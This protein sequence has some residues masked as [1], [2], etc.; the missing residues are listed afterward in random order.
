MKSNKLSYAT[1]Y[2]QVNLNVLS[3]Y[4]S[5]LKDCP[6]TQLHVILNVYVMELNNISDP[7]LPPSAKHSRDITIV[8]MSELCM[9]S[10]GEEVW[11]IVFH[12]IP[13]MKWLIKESLSSAYSGVDKRLLQG[14][15]NEPYSRLLP[16][17]RKLVTPLTVNMTG[18][19]EVKVRWE[20][21]TC[22]MRTRAAVVDTHTHTHN[23]PILVK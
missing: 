8:E 6:L 16:Q 9:Y 15:L 1:A 12:V 18:L 19:E 20:L 10:F 3:L 21:C 7:I 5:V 14:H 22:R 2:S 23:S 11:A 17:V 13:L 4:V